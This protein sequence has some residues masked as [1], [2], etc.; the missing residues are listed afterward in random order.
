MFK[1]RRGTGNLRCEDG[2]MSGRGVDVCLIVPTE[3]AYD[4]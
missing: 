1:S 4:G 3:A 2:I